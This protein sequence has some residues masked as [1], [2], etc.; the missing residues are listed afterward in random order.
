MNPTALAV[1]FTIKG[2]VFSYGLPPINH[3]LRLP[4]RFQVK[5]FLELPKIKWVTSSIL[6]TSVFTDIFIAA[7]LTYYLHHLRNAF[8]ANTLVNGLI[9]YSIETGAI[10]RWVLYP[11]WAVMKL[12]IMLLSLCG[13]ATLIAVCSQAFGLPF[14]L[15]RSF[16]V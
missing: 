7:S 6:A 11:S 13:I 15:T 2:Y 1:I 16:E 5:T 8:S 4:S 10:T 9:R 12:I 14:L 3:W